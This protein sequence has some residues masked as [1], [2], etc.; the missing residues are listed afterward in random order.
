MSVAVMSIGLLGAAGLQLTALR[1]NNQSYERSQAAV[2]AY[3]I[4]DAMRAN[5]LAAADG[6]FELAAGAVP[7]EAVEC[8]QDKVCTRAESAAFALDQWMRRVRRSLPAGAASIGC[9]AEPCAVGLMQTVT[10]FWDEDR[11]GADGMDCPPAASFDPQQD[12]A[13]LRVSF[14]P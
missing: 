12:L 9:S 5:R 3:E 6:D 2:L 7:E 13:C 1:S 11:T 14:T 10:L 4:A 8:T